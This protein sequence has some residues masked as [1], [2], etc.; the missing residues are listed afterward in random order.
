MRRALD[1]LFAASLWLAALCLL[2]IAA[3]VGLQVAG[4]L[5]D[6]ILKTAG[7][8]QTGFVILS[9]AE[10]AGYLLVAAS[11]LA[12]G[13]TLK[14]GAHIRVTLILG[15][16]P[17]KARTAIEAA[18]LAFAAAA[19]AYGTWHLASF[20]YTSFLY[21]ELSPGLIPVPLAY[22][23]TAMAFGA[24]VLT[25]AFLDELAITLTRGRPS[26]RAAE[27]AISLGQEG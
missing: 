26:F 20:A 22:P 21:N 17:P 16:L 2:A 12:L 14:S 15:A 11:F 8:S 27:D 4:R 9:L 19:A 25:V 13:A 5:L 1:G 18:A 23:Q 6:A 24:A 10:I 3:L 7:S